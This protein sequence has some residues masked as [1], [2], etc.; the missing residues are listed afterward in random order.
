MN[1]EYDWFNW[2]K[3][4][5]LSVRTMNKCYA[6]R[7]KFQAKI[8]WAKNRTFGLTIFEL[9]INDRWLKKNV[10]CSLFGRYW[11]IGVSTDSQIRPIRSVLSFVISKVSATNIGTFELNIQ[12]KNYILKKLSAKLRRTADLFSWPRANYYVRFWWTGFKWKK[13]FIT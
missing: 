4:E 8:C 5:T 10:E 6:V 1:A 12:E 7:S 13:N 3:C 9:T 2:L 11:D